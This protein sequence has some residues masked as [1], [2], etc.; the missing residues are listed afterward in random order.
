M[1]KIK[2]LFVIH[3]FNLGG[4][5]RLVM[6]QLANVDRV[7]FEPWIMTMYPEAPGSIADQVRIEQG[8]FYRFNFRGPKSGLFDIASWL[9]LYRFLRS[10][11]FD[12]VITNLF[13]ANLIVR[14]AARC[15][16]VPVILSYE[17]CSA[18]NRA[19]WQR[20]VDWALAGVTDA[21]FVSSLDVAR[22]FV[23][24]E[25]IPETKFVINYNAPLLTNIALSDAEIADIKKKLGLP[26]D[27]FVITGA[28]RLVEQKGFRYLID[29]AR[30][31]LER[32]KELPLF[33]LIF[34]RGALEDELRG[35]I[36]SLGLEKKV[37]LAGLA[38][39]EHIIGITD[40]F[41]MPELFDGLALALLEAMACGKAV[42]VSDVNGPREI[43][44]DGVNGVLIPPHSSDD[45]AQVLIRLINNPALRSRLGE[46]AHK[47]SER[48]SIK[49]NVN[50]IQ[51]KI[52]SL[53]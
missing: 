48:F 43:I 20:L 1:K 21:I 29:A 28:G 49:N 3:R 26:A 37:L 40:I 12:A 51:D 50:V 7:R 17:H 15:A 9:K 41:A 35:Q 2:I 5:E 30:S 19:R 39:M 33:V 36:Y 8:R 53:L 52:V 44:R 6:N 45:L 14:V 18:P 47:D 42:A 16:R 34:G 4:A 24:D 11:R 31:V 23:R 38:P 27:A 10:E 25:H 13:M 46:Q 22:E 32:N